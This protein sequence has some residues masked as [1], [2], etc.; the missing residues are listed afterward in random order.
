MNRKNLSNF[1]KFQLNIQK[2]ELYSPEN[3][4]TD[5]LINDMATM[6]I[7]KV[8]QKDGGTQL[9]L[10]IEYENGALA[11][12][13]PMRFPRDR[14]ADPNLFY[15][16]DFERHNSEIATFH[17]DRLLGFHRTPPTV[18]RVLNVTSEIYALADDEL[19]KTFFISPAN[20]LCFHGKCGYYCDTAHAF[21][22]HPDTLEGSFAAFLPGKNLAP[23]KV[24]RHPYRRS[25]HKRRKAVWE[26]DSTYC[27]TVVKKQPPYDSGRRLL[28]LM[29]MAVLDFLIGNMDRHHY[30]TFKMFGNDTFTLHLDH[31]RGFGLPRH[32][33]LSI[34]EPIRQCCLF[35]QST[36]LRLLQ[37]HT[38]QSEPN[39]SRWPSL[40][41]AMRSSL[42]KDP[43]NPVLTEA[44]LIA[45]DRRVYITLTTL[46][47]CLS[48]KKAQDVF[49]ANDNDY[50]SHPTTKAHLHSTDN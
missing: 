40:S 37:F 49:F 15:F 3:D 19:L 46:R 47:E 4:Y 45:L 16:V 32:D 9:K 21:C 27:D 41:Q 26:N 22:G 14:E 23:R 35:R 43:V 7:V 39:G 6:A 30:E 5:R 20:N 18:G 48:K 13:K 38:R 17:L 50:N 10:T 29:D 11:L 2:N 44:N 34:L 24:W 1:E 33:E 25:Y 8:S 31:G 12:L 36:L 28:D 42:A